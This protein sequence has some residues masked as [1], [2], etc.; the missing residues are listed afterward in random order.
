MI[1]FGFVAIASAAFEYQN[2]FVGKC[3]LT[4]KQQQLACTREGQNKYAIVCQ[5]MFGPDCKTVTRQAGL[6]TFDNE[7]LVVLGG[8]CKLTLQKQID[9]NGVKS[10]E[11]FWMLKC[12]ETPESRCLVQNALCYDNKFVCKPGFQLNTFDTVGHYDKYTVKD[13]YSLVWRTQSYTLRMYSE[14]TEVA[15]F[16]NKDVCVQKLK[17]CVDET[18]RSIIDNAKCFQKKN[19]K[20][21][22]IEVIECRDDFNLHPSLFTVIYPNKKQTYDN[23][24]LIGQR[25][26]KDQWE[27]YVR[28]TKIRR[29]K[30]KKVIMLKANKV[31]QK[32]DEL[33]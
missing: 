33:P 15:A 5:K 30:N 12:D 25:V 28:F 6:M 18:G 4:R 23:F 29:G 8:V 20:N 16:Y 32:P 24:E 31:C 10:G 27:L 17:K 13:A 26:A 19:N 1:K 2:D 11:A 22:V 14:G 7:Q 3:R 21:Q 9:E